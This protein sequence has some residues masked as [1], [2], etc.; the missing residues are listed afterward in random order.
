MCSGVSPKLD[1]AY[2]HRWVFPVAFV[3]LGPI[4]EMASMWKKAELCL[5]P[6]LS[7]VYIKLL[8]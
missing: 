5:R 3:S 2:A 8:C 7:T 6:L 4:I 1:R